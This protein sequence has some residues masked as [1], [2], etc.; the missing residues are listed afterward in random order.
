[1][2]YGILNSLQLFQR[3]HQH[4]LQRY[5]IKNT[6]FNADYVEVKSVESINELS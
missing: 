3:F 5:F 1:M 2:I 4:A 6:F